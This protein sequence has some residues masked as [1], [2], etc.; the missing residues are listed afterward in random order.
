MPAEPAGSDVNALACSNSSISAIALGCA[1]P[2]D[3]LG[4]E[5]VEQSLGVA[6]PIL[7]CAGKTGEGGEHVAVVLAERQP[8]TVG[9]AAVDGRGRRHRHAVHGAVQ[10]A[11]PQVPRRGEVLEHGIGGVERR[12]DDRVLLGE[13]VGDRCEPAFGGGAGCLPQCDAAVE[14]AL[15]LEAERAA[16]GVERLVV[17]LEVAGVAPVGQET[18]AQRF[19]QL[20]K[21]VGAT[22]RCR[23]GRVPG[24]GTSRRRRR[25][26]RHRAHRWEPPRRGRRAGRG[27]RTG[28]RR[29]RRRRPTP[30]SRRPC[31]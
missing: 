20:G 21:A 1:D 3:P 5:R 4:G 6:A 2:V 18:P 16:L 13:H 10:Q 8:H 23:S 7:G 9:R 15:D 12:G 11:G 29:R 27:R 19:Q 28:C 30:P 17:L 24:P 22:R 26:R 14:A 25:R 31:R